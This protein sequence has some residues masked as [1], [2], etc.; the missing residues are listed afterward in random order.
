MRRGRGRRRGEDPPQPFS[1]AKMFFRKI[2]KHKIFTCEEHVT[3]YLLKKTQVTKSRSFFS[4]FIVL[5]V[6]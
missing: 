3:L 2:G 6:N 5:A 1:G 4:E